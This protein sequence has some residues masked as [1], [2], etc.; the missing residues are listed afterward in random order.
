MTLLERRRD[1]TTGPQPIDPRKLKPLGEAIGHRYW[2]HERFPDN[3]LREHPVLLPDNELLPAEPAVEVTGESGERLWRTFSVVPSGTYERLTAPRPGQRVR[4]QRAVS[5]LRKLSRF[6][7]DATVIIPGQ[8]GGR[9]A[10]ADSK[11]ALEYVAKSEPIDDGARLVTGRPRASTPQAMLDR[12][13]AKR[14]ELRVTRDGRLV[15]FSG[16]GL[17]DDAT[18]EAIRRAAPLLRPLLAGTAPATCEAPGCRTAAVD[19]LEPESVLACAEHVAPE[20]WS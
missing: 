6:R 14:V 7:G 12:I 20:A 9:L 4:P 17:L 5:A 16:D 19:V 1:T 8:S 11:E 2:T 15:A 13:K 18:R 10:E 3:E